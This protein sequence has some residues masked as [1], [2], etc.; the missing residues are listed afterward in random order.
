MRH[1][2]FAFLDGAH[3]MRD[4]QAGVP[5]HADKALDRRGADARIKRPRE[6]NQD[7]D[8]GVGEELAAAIAAHRDERRT[9]RRA[10]REPQPAHDAVDQRGMPHQQALG[11][12]VGSEGAFQR[13]APG[14]ELALP[15]GYSRICGSRGR[16]G[17]RRGYQR[18][19]RPAPRLAPAGCRRKPSTPRSRRR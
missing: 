9:R 7:V 16:G 6:Q 11:L 18:N 8:V 4:F 3:R 17:K 5:E 14:D 12:R 13:G 15:P 1:L 2:G 10:D 19:V